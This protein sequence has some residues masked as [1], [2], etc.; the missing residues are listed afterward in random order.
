MV[1]DS[2]V[3]SRERI[4]LGVKILHKYRF[5][6]TDPADSQEYDMR[7]QMYNTSFYTVFGALPFSWYIHA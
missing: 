6:I 5:M 4:D 7:K 1:D 3:P 2:F